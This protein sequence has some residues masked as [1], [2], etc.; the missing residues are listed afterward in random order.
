MYAGKNVTFQSVVNP[1]ILIEFFI[2]N[3]VKVM[4][5]I[6]PCLIQRGHYGLEKCDVN[7]CSKHGS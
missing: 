2:S 1:F 4:T 5:K 3:Y 6:Q 7:D